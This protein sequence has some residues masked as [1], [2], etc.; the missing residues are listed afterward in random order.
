MFDFTS[1]FFLFFI[2]QYTPAVYL[3]CLPEAFNFRGKT[4]E[5]LKAHLNI[6]VF[7]SYQWHR[8]NES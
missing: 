2:S 3:L 4:L 1:V 6:F 7:I 8:N 5:I